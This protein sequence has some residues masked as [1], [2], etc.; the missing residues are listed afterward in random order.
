[1][2]YEEKMG[3]EAKDWGSNTS[4]HGIPQIVRSESPVTKT[5]WLVLYLTCLA[6]FFYQAAMVV[7]T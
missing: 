4:A 5:L 3:H 6:N 1:V 7:A 2:T